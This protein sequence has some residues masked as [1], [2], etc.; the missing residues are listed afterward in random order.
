MRKTSLYLHCL[1]LGFMFGFMQSALG[2]KSPG[3]TNELAKLKDVKKNISDIASEIKKISL[4]IASVEDQLANNFKKYLQAA[5]ERKRIEKMVAEMTKGLEANEL[6]LKLNLENTQKMLKAGLIKH[7]DANPGPADLI[8]KKMIINSL[9]IQIEGV[10]GELL[11]NQELKTQIDD[12]SNRVAEYTRIEMSLKTLLLEQEE[13]KKLISNRYK[14]HLEKQTYL[15][16]KYDK[17]RADLSN[18]KKKVFPEIELN[19]NNRFRLP[20]DSVQLR[21]KNNG[22][23]I[24]IGHDREIPLFATNTGTVVYVGDLSTYGKLVMIDHGHGLRSVILGNYTVGI[25]KGDRVK[26][27]DIIGKTNS[28]LNQHGEVYFEVRKGSKTQNTSLLI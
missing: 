20:L 2:A 9:A 6:N 7:I 3:Q 14:E 25:K 12:L 17:M 10:K 4:S 8:A 15:S 26:K 16:S 27:G 24:Y 5:S 28:S 1:I 13:E 21:Y 18:K 19:A 23:G 11:K 22:D